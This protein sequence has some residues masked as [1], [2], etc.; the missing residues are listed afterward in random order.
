MSKFLVSENMVTISPS[1]GI[2]ITDPTGKQV[3]QYPVTAESLTEL[4]HE[5]LVKHHRGELPKFHFDIACRALDVA[6]EMP[7]AKNKDDVQ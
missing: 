5:C 7:R 6:R 2:R 3:G 4:A 1:Q